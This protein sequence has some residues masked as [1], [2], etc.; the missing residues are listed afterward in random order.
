MVNLIGSFNM[1]RLAADA[2]CKN[3]PKPPASA[4]C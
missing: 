4:A 1:I 2:M 3:E